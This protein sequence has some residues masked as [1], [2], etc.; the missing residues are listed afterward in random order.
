MQCCCCTSLL[1]L[2]LKN[3]SAGEH[4]ASN[5]CYGDCSVVIVQNMREAGVKEPGIH[6]HE[7][8]EHTFEWFAVDQVQSV[9]QGSGPHVDCGG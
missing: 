8:C 3:P 9:T 6:V 2:T 7:Q 5:E 4:P 1:Q